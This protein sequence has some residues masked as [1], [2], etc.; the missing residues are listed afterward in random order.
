MHDTKEEIRS[1]WLAQIIG[2]KKLFID[3]EYQISTS[4]LSS[5][6]P[7]NSRVVLRRLCDLVKKATKSQK[8]QFFPPKT[9]VPERK[10]SSNPYLPTFATEMGVFPV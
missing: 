2:E 10:L 5:L 3:Q 9:Y 8:V 4:E 6:D 1:S 7:N